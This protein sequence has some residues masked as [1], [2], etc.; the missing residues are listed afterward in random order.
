VIAGGYEWWRRRRGSLTSRED[1]WADAVLD[2]ARRP[3]AIAEIRATMRGLGA[4]T[5]RTRPDH[6]RLSVLLAELLDADGKSDD[7]RRVLDDVNVAVIDPVTASLVRHGR[8][9]VRLRAGDAKGARAALAEVRTTGVA[10]LDARIAL[11]G[12]SIGIELGEH[13][14]ALATATRVRQEAGADE[15]LLTEA[16]VV[17]A[18]ALD[19]AGQTE[20]AR[21]IVRSLGPAMIEVLRALG[22]P[23]V[24]KLVEP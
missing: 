20:E 7:A 1:A 10:E 24:R 14:A 21:T 6:A 2:R 4:L 19:A 13:E 22:S 15:Q 18:A 3:G 17:R 11:L 5:S 9:V 12:A 23:R 8:A 16:R